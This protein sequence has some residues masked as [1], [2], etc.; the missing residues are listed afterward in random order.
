M[1]TW[2]RYRQKDIDLPLTG[3]D[4]HSVSM[5]PCGISAP[6]YSISPTGEISSCTLTFNDKN[7]YSKSYDIGKVDTNSLILDT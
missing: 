5:Y 2:K 3:T 4:I 6:N 7:T 1:E